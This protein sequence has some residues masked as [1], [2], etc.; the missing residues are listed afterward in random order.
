MGSLDNTIVFLV[1]RK[2]IPDGYYVWLAE[3]LGRH[4]RVFVMS[5]WDYPYTFVN[6]TY[7]HMSD[8]ECL[9]SNYKYCVFNKVD[10]VGKP[11]PRHVTAWDKMLLYLN[12]NDVQYEHVW[13][14]EDDV[15]MHSANHALALFERYKDNPA[16]Y[17]AR[18]FFNLQGHPGWCQW[19]VCDGVFNREHWHGAFTPLC[20]LSKTLVQ[21]CDD[22]AKE[23]GC[24]ALIEAL[25]PSLC[26]KHNL[27]VDAGWLAT[28]PIRTC[29]DVS[30]AEIRHT[31][32]Q[33]PDAIFHP[34]ELS[35]AEKFA[36]MNDQTLP[37]I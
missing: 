9:A 20:R 29:P 35:D 7:L 25:F 17:I 16:D 19:Y 31:L 5:D 30:E 33:F 15:Y 26:A 28:C 8:T 11:C 27:R 1:T 34:V 14:I 2:V 32:A 13:L 22:L 18:D 6:A 36:L 10:I 12:K 4:M 23:K 37:K 3:A 24:L 21:K